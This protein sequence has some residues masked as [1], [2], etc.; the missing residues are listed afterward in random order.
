MKVLLCGGT[1]GIGLALLERLLQN[2]VYESI[3]VLGRNFEKIDKN[4]DHSQRVKR[5]VCDIGYS[6]QI[7]QAFSQIEGNIDV[8]V[9]FHILSNV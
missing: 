1:D 5:L 4:L 9:C 6:T 7:E 2:P 8:R 3:Y